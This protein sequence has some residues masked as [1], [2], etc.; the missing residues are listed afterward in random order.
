MPN[1]RGA[2]ITARMRYVRERHG[3]DGVRRVL[4]AVEAPTRR[5]LEGRVSAHGW[6]DYDAF[7]DLGV[8]VD[9][10]FGSGDLALRLELGR[11]SAEVNLPTI[12]R[13]FYRFGSPLYIFRRAAQLWGEH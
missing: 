12:Y 9:R 10:L 3:E 4:D 8:T 7:V 11:Y 2:M 6:V 5:V 13:L 1:V